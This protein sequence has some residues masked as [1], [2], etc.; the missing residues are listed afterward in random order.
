MSCS[1]SKKKNRG[2]TLVEL[3]IV[4]AIIAILISIGFSS[5]GRVQKNSRDTQRRSDLRSVAGA[6]EQYYSDFNRYPPM[7]DT[8]KDD[9]LPS[10]SHVTY[11][12][13]IPTNPT[14]STQ[15]TY[16]QSEVAAN[17]LP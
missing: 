11:L 7:L 4:I 13:D 9:V 15:P 2:F 16:N 12:K 6:L 17:E 8:L 3:L 14:T 10:G 1:L 5:Y